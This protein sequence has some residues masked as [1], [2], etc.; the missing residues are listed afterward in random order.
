MPAKRAAT[1]TARADPEPRWRSAPGSTKRAPAAAARS[2]EPSGPTALRTRNRELAAE[3]AAALAVSQR[4]VDSR[5]DAIQATHVSWHAAWSAKRDALVTIDAA[6]RVDDG[7]QAALRAQLRNLLELRSSER[8]HARDSRDAQDCAFAHA[9]AHNAALRD[10]RR[11]AAP[12][13]RALGAGLID[14]L[15]NL[16]QLETQLPPRRARDGR[17]ARPRF[18]RFQRASCRC[19]RPPP[20]WRPV[21][22][23]PWFY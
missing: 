8:N 2:Q 18:R 3:L 17:P 7:H 23:S 14:I 15:C 1:T 12:K 5:E 21:F 19:R 20:T 4:A 16:T 22:V 11:R 13:L 6:R 9:S 10:T